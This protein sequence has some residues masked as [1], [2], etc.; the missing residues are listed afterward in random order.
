[1]FERIFVDP[2]V[3]G[4]KPCIKGTRI[5]VAMVLELLED[6]LSFDEILTDYYPTLTRADIKACIEYARWLVEGEEVY[7][8]EETMTV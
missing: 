6:G 2:R 5:P 8:I 1:M 7:F 4:G 3:C